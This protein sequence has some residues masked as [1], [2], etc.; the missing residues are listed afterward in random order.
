MPFDRDGGILQQ[1]MGEGRGGEISPLTSPYPSCSK[2]WVSRHCA[3][4]VLDR[5]YAEGY[6]V[7]ASCGVGQSCV[8]TL[9][10]S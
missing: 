9:F 4:T 10:K 2:L 7:I 8:W 6:R 1:K 3:R 5:L